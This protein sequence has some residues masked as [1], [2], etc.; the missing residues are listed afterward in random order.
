LVLTKEGREVLDSHSLDRD[1]G[2]SQA[3]QAGVSRPREIDHDS[4]LYAT[5]CQEEARLRDDHPDLEIRRVILEQDLKREYQEFLQDQTG[6][7]RTATDDPTAPTTRSA[8]GRG[9][10]TCRTSMARCISRITASSTR[11]TAANTTRMSSCS[12]PTTAALMPPVAG[13]PASGST[14]SRHAVAAVVHGRIH[15]SWRTSCDAGIPAQPDIR[16][17]G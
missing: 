8:T 3:F 17:C 1:D 12:R 10:T 5:F 13:R 11:S 15:A 16:Q 2:A 9:S 7:D 4:S 14:L 6:T